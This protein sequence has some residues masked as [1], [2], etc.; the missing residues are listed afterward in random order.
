MSK[1][2]ILFAPILC[3]SLISLSQ[4]KITVGRPYEVVDGQ[5]KLYFS[6][7][8][9]LLA[10]KTDDERLYLQKLNTQTLSFINI[11]RF[12]IPVNGFESIEVIKGRYFIF[13]STNIGLYVREI[14]FES[15][16]FK[17]EGRKIISARRVTGTDI[18]SG[19]YAIPRGV[20]N[21]YRIFVSNDE[22]KVGVQYTVRPEVIDDHL[23]YEII[24]LHIFDNNLQELSSCRKRMPYTE[25]KMNNLNY[26][27]DSNG[28]FYIV[29]K[30][31]EREFYNKAD[32]NSAVRDYHLEILKL[33]LPDTNFT[34][35]RV[36]HE[37]N[38]FKTIEMYE[39]PR[40]KMLSVGFYSKK[41][42]AT[43]NIDGIV[44]FK[45]GTDNH[46]IDFKL[47]ELPLEVKNQY[48]EEKASVVNNEWLD[49]ELKHLDLQEIRFND[50][51]S[52][53]I[54]SEQK[55]S[56][57]YDILVMKLDADENMSWIKRLPKGRAVGGGRRYFYYLPGKEIHHFLF[58]DDMKNFE[59]PINKPYPT[60]QR[61]ADILMAYS[62]ND[63]NGMVKKT[64][65]LDFRKVQGLELHLFTLFRISP[66]APSI[67][68]FEAYKK[69]QEDILIKVDL[70][71]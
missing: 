21:R 65:I 1:K 43:S 23:S 33:T 62:V 32:T 29:T 20:S 67:F 48:G 50:D 52:Q 2:A 18:V 66:I 40:G 69:R 55:K 57:A 17:D 8:N 16:N 47:Y 10:V 56:D 31:F 64:A 6:K 59:L 26:S 34:A 46:P 51:G 38:F 53:V 27:F 22:S 41:P 9:E 45:L 4:S 13:Y 3:L 19:M 30:V 5:G 35:I 61:S 60:W 58:L 25:I 71:E 49:L 36:A 63:T 70:S 37:G 42:S 68:V 11:N 14:D 12:R 24:G 39:R 15:G 28:N 44:Q 7:G 54:I